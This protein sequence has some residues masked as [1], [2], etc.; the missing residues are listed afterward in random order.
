MI[1]L[2]YSCIA[3]LVLGFA[4]V[5]FTLMY[6]GFRY[7]C[8]FT[9]GTQVSTGG[10]CYQRALKQLTVGL[11]LAEICLIGLYG[12]G[13]GTT[14]QAIGPLVLMVIC[15]VA[16]II[17]QVMLGRH[18]RKLEE[19][20][21]DEQVVENATRGG[22]GARDV[23]KHAHGNGT[24]GTNG[25]NGGAN[26]ASVDADGYDGLLYAPGHKQT[27]PETNPNKSGVM[28]SIKNLIKPKDA[29]FEHILHMAPHLSTPVR[30]YTQREHMEAYMHPAAVS[31]TPIVWIARDIH[32]IS[33][34]EVHD[35]KNKIGEGFE[36]T[37]EGAWFNEKGKVEW[38]QDDLKQ[39]PVW[40]DEPVY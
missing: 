26:G 10:R 8:L 4:T 13:I 11:Y 25:T 31:E 5:G 12:I 19:T 23:E 18:L 40:E 14:N 36:M 32:G 34:K 35:S 33:Q 6:L 21:P 15:L 37:D 27:A 20:F 7:N 17:W 28:S 38:K 2:A 3:P 22:M 24:N 29:A 16:T 9:F 30:P 39:A 1:A